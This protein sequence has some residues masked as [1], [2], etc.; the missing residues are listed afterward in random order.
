MW[1]ASRGSLQWGVR[2]GLSLTT[3][4]GTRLE[5]KADAIS[6]GSGGEIIIARH[7]FGRPRKSHKDGRNA[8]RHA[9]YVAAARQTWPD[10]HVKVVLHYLTGNERVDTTPIER[11][12]SGRVKKLTSYAEKI[13][14]GD[15]PAKPGR[16]CMRCPWNL[17]CPSSA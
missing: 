16:E 13:K 8:D 14:E 7:R 4:G 3:K 9:L 1:Q 2:E 5:V 6:Q 11:V 10:N 15:F 12:I 17:V